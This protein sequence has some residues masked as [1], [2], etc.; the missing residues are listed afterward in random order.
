ME[1]ALSMIR[2]CL[3]RS[4]GTHVRLIL[5]IGLLLSITP[6]HAAEAPITYPSGYTSCE[7]SLVA[8]LPLDLASV[9]KTRE[10]RNLNLKQKVAVFHRVADAA[11][12]LTVAQDQKLDAEQMR[13]VGLMIKQIGDSS[14][15]KLEPY[16]QELTIASMG[17]S[18]S[19]TRPMEKPFARI[20]I[21]FIDRLLSKTAYMNANLRAYM[22]GGL[23]RDLLFLLD[24]RN[25][26]PTLREA[27]RFLAAAAAYNFDMTLHPGFA[28]MRAAIELNLPSRTRDDLD[29]GFGHFA[30]R[31]IGH[32]RTRLRMV[33][34]EPFEGS[35]S[36]VLEQVDEIRNLPELVQYPR[37]EKALARL[38]KE[39][40]NDFPRERP[41]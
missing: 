36:W 11:K 24:E 2:A 25:P 29:E 21:G 34:D 41:N 5:F 27:D 37:T 31:A 16:A 30:E 14:D 13:I 10:F 15:K 35:F 12:E 3:D 18:V 26:G 20:W 1:R 33:S 4:K 28:F 17:L 32:L 6:V 8:Q 19:L 22:Y 7:E 38:K 9:E 39:I 40:E 23:V